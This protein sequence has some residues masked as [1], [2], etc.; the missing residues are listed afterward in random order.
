MQSTDPS[1]LIVEDNEQLGA[2]YCKVLA[3]IGL[4]TYHT[5]SVEET[6]VRLAAITP[7][8]VLLDMNMYDGNGHIIVEYLKVNSRFKYTEIIIASGGAQYRYYAE[9]QGIDHY[10][11]K[12]ISIPILVDFM[13]R[14]LGDRLPT[15]IS[16]GPLAY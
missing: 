14:L 9:D 3:H 7:D 1:I 6:L 4:Q 15:R 16:L 13:K 10:F 8:I 5:T 11:Q 2:L 12:P